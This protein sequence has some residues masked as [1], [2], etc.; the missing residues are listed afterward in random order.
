MQRC[1][2]IWGVLSLCACSGTTIDVGPGATDGSVNSAGGSANDSG[3]SA[4]S[5]GGSV[6]P[7]AGAMFVALTGGAA[8]RANNVPAEAACTDEKP[9]APWPAADAC[10]GASDL[11]VVGTWHGYVEQQQPPWD[12]LTLVIQGA[13]VSGGV[14]GTLTVGSG[15]VV[16][17]PAN[18]PNQ[19][20][21]YPN[22]PMHGGI[23]GVP[24]RLLKGNTDGTRLRFTVSNA[25]I[26]RSWC[27]LQD[28]YR[29][30]GR[31]ECLPRWPGSGP[32]DGSFT[33]LD[34]AGKHNLVVSASRQDQCSRIQP[35][36]CNA[37]GC[38]ASPDALPIDFDL[39]V[40]ANT[41]EG[42]ASRYSG[43]RVYFTRVP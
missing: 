34:P 17:A 13:S 24:M 35:C 29:V 32:G 3:G 27:A 5:S 11:P 15:P 42:T 22:F 26:M 40:A 18:N 19:D 2:W 25:E 23:P 41:A 28:S 38:D 7:S 36:A 10:A 33:F 43:P 31:C 14:C 8:G 30:E 20:Y 4:N 6:F 9:L 39:R 37:Q 1:S 21:P 16:V 12:D